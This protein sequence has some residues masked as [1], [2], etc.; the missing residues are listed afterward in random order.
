MADHTMQNA[1]IV[2]SL[3]S[4]RR[5]MV[6]TTYIKPPIPTRDNDWQAVLDNYEPGEP[7]GY[8]PTEADAVCS[9]YIEI[10]QREDEQQFEFAEGY[11]H[12]ELEHP[13]PS[14]KHFTKAFC[15]GW[16]QARHEY[17]DRA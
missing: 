12:F 11:R 5:V 14:P 10:A 17:E 4:T 8:G 13:K 2:G 15:R 6:I 16:E 3:G 1:K 7:I 9:L